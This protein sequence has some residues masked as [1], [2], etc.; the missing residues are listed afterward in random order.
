MSRKN[1]QNPVSTPLYCAF[2][3]YLSVIVS[4]SLPAAWGQEFVCEPAENGTA[5]PD[6]DYVM[7]VIKCNASP[8]VDGNHPGSSD[9]DYGYENGHVIK[10]DGVYH[11]L[12]TELFDAS[13][14]PELPGWVPARVGYWTSIDGD[15][16]ERVCTI[17]QG[18]ATGRPDDYDDPKNN[19]WS[20][21]WYWNKQENRWNIF[22]RGSWVWR[23]RS[24]VEGPNGFAGPYTEAAKIYPPLMG[25]VP[26]WDN[27]SLASFGNVFT[28][29]DGKYCSFVGVGDFRNPDDIQWVNGLAWADN[30]N[31][32]WTRVETD[33]H[34]TF[35]YSENPF[36]D[37][38]EINGQKV[39]FCVY[40][41]LSNQH[42]IGYGY[43]FDGVNWTGKTLD[44]T[45]HVD[46]ADNYGFVYSIRTPCCLIREDDGTYTVIF[47]AYA[48][49]DDVRPKGFYAIARVNVRI[50]QTHK[51]SDTNV[52]F[53][54]DMNN[55]K[56]IC[57]DCDVQYGREYSLA[58]NDTYCESVSTAATYADVTVEATLRCVEQIWDFATAKAGVYVRKTDMD[59]NLGESGYHACLTAKGTVQLYA[60]NNLLAEVNVEKRPGIFRRLTLSVKGDN[61]KV[62]YDGAEEPCIDINDATY[63]EGYAGLVAYRSHWHYERV[64]ITEN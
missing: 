27:D 63:A 59:G 54:G 2:V 47:T 53:P 31:G 52:V 3:I 64:K 37:I 56:T 29:E 45:G 15:H 41:D 49:P 61:I 1:P 5:L 57:G 11:M 17:V 43:S 44:L 8:V 18:T 28:A 60:G 7:S 22:W 40:D 16:W 26:Y 39:Y 55:W 30:L 58:G 21:S 42:S 19:T 34:P 12:M 4:G 36:V 51:P 50:D 62:Y 10:V 32:P 13:S 20:S 6:R 24:E 33:G 48:P 14:H 46:W 35:V 23:Y 38:H 25:G 9:N